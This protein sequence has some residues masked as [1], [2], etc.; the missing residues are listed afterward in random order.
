MT[1]RFALACALALAGLPA[2]GEEGKPARLYTNEDLDRIAPRR[3]ETGALSRP[4]PSPAPRAAARESGETA[5]ASTKGEAYW[6]REASRVRTQVRTLEEQASR[7]R[8]QIERAA[9]RP[10][11]GKNRQGRPRESWAAEDN[12]SRRLR[13]I[14]ARARELESNLEDRARREGAP[15]GWLR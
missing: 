6:R 4:G 11:T 9:N 3:G 1:K 2:I 14:E 10:S 12:R 8:E 15:P 13:E 5:G 7:V